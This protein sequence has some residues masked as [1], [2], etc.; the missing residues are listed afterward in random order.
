MTGL[1]KCGIP[2]HAT[3]NIVFL[4]LLG[5]R[6]ALTVSKLHKQQKT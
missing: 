2:N 4:P 5:K 3:C 6:N 1:C